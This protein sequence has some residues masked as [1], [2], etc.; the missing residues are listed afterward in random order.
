MYLG[1]HSP[2]DLIGG[3]SIGLVICSVWLLFGDDIDNFV[4]SSSSM[5]VLSLSFFIFLVIVHPR[6]TTPSYTRAVAMV[7]LALGII[8][9][10]HIHYTQN[11]INEWVGLHLWKFLQF[12]LEILHQSSFWNKFSPQVWRIVIRLSFGFLLLNLAFI[13]TQ[14]CSFYI[15]L[16]IFRIPIVAKIL[17]PINTVTSFVEFPSFKPIHPPTKRESS[18]H[19]LPAN[20]STWSKFTASVIISIVVTQTVPCVFKVMDLMYFPNI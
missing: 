14:Q 2:L 12:P 19:K 10:S 4:T 5:E 16:A 1:V 9:G 8:F 3:T 17:K 20:P 13:F 6:S 7:G 15:Y 11:W 18:L